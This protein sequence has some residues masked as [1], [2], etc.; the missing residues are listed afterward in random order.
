MLGDALRLAAAVDGVHDDALRDGFL[1]ALLRINR[2]LRERFVAGDE[3]S[4]VHLR[5]RIP[6]EV[7]VSPAGSPRRSIR[8]RRSW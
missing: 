3:D 5:I 6:G 4:F 2:T 7:L 8:R 1:A